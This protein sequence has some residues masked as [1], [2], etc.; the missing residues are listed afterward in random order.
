MAAGQDARPGIVTFEELIAGHE[1]ANRRRRSGNE[2]YLSYTGGTT[3]LPKGVVLEMEKVTRA[4]A[5]DTRAWIL[6]LPESTIGADSADLAAA[7]T[8]AGERPVALP[9][10]PL[11]HGAGFGWGSLPSLTAGGSVVTLANRSFDADTVLKAIDRR[12]VTAMTIVGD[13][14]ARPL[15][16]AL[17]NSAHEGSPYDAS[18][19]RVISS[20]GAP[21]SAESKHGLF[22]H[23]PN[24]A[25]VDGC[26]CTEGGTYGINIRDQGAAPR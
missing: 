25:L 13:A 5:L 16:H 1:P 23:M 17:D 26:G 9:A 2:F 19:L 18:S 4:L 21:W 11:V 10:S 24:V 15:V 7:L 14:F 6:G 3:G 12:R 8:Q 20:G 22:Q